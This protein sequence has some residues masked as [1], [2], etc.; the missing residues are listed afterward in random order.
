MLFTYVVLLQGI[1][2]FSVGQ[3][4]LTYA[5]PSSPLNDTVLGLFTGISYQNLTL[6]LILEKKKYSKAF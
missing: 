4:L 6:L 1:F 5:T 2:L 3:G